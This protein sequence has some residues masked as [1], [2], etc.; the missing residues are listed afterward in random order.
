MLLSKL[1][2][3]PHFYLQ[4]VTKT[5]AREHND[6]IEQHVIVSIPER[7]RYAPVRNSERSH[8]NTV[9]G[10]CITYYCSI[11]GLW[12]S[13][14]LRDAALWTSKSCKLVFV[15]FIFLKMSR[16]VPNLAQKQE[17]QRN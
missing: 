14:P 12:R 13:S 5:T 1:N 2:I 9:G 7:L 10:G 6:I 4:F 17:G 11:N 16:D 15:Y 8:F 3:C